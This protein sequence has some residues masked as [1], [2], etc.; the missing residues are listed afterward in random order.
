[1]KKMIPFILLIAFFI[2]RPGFAS[3]AS[4]KPSSWTEQT[5]YG[6][7]TAHKLG[8]GLLNLTMGWSAIP[9]EI[10]K[11]ADTNPFTGLAKGLWLSVTN[12]VG[13][14]LH[15]VTFPVPVDIP[16]SA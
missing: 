3:F 13:G 6:D 1:M 9:Y 5:N 10:E 14:A 16:L 11:T 7:K 12:T 8:F 15:T 2:P 4:V